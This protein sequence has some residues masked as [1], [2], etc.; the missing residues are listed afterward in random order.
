MCRQLIPCLWARHSE[1]MSAKVRGSGTDHEVATSGRSQSLSAA[2]W[3]DWSAI[4]SISYWFALHYFM[5]PSKVIQSKKNWKNIKR[6]WTICTICI[7][8]C[9]M[10][11]SMTVALILYWSK[12]FI[13]RLNILLYHFISQIFII[14]H[15]VHVFLLWQPHLTLY[16]TAHNLYKLKNFELKTVVY[17]LRCVPQFW[18]NLPHMPH[19]GAKCNY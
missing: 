15:T 12:Y 3:C 2:N 4:C 18:M 7:N 6:M 8:V 5:W 10:A 16:V 1:C 17:C 14:S 11:L 19:M 13:H 9:D